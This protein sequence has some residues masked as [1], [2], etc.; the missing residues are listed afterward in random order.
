MVLCARLK[1]GPTHSSVSFG[2]L[3]CSLL[4]EHG[5][6]KFSTGV[7]DLQNHQLVSETI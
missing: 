7:E 5:K 3:F 6:K 1:T 4:R 2:D